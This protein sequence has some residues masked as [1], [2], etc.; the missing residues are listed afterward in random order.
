MSW[1]F[2]D[3]LGDGV[4]DGISD[5]AGRHAVTERGEGEKNDAVVF[6]I[7]EEFGFGEIGVR[8][9][10]DDGGLDARGFDDGLEFFERDVGK[11]DG[12]ALDRKSVV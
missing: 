4:D 11:A 2:I 1:R 12:A 6:A 3:A 5:E 7:L 10:L 9:D 8:F